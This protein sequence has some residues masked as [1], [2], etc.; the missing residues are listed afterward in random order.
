MA[1]PEN[2]PWVAAAVT[3]LA[4]LM[5]D[6][7]RTNTVLLGVLRTGRLLRQDHATA[8]DLGARTRS[9]T[10]VDLG[11]GEAILGRIPM[12]PASDALGGDGQ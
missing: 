10:V 4:E 11:S 3:R 2:T 8:E 12:N 1:G 9:E 7:M 5:A 6:E